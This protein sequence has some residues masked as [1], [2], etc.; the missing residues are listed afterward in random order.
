MFAF[1]KAWMVNLWRQTDPSGLAL[2]E[3]QRY[4]TILMGTHLAQI[5]PVVKLIL[6]L[7]LFFTSVL[8]AIFFMVHGFYTLSPGN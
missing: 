3:I 2:G 4:F 1:D 7:A 5:H 8:Y 6:V